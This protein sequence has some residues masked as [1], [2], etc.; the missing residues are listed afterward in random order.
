MKK[1]DEGNLY[2]DREYD[3][4][5]EPLEIQMSPDQGKNANKIFY[6]EPEDIEKY[7]NG[8]DVEATNPGERE[9]DEVIANRQNSDVVGVSEEELEDFLVSGDRSADDVDDDDRFSGMDDVFGADLEEGSCTEQEIAEGTCGH[10]HTADGEELS[11]PGGT[12]GMNANTR[13]TLIAIREE[14]NQLIK[15]I[16]KRKK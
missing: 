5:N 10:T 4:G 12:N 11:T 2:I 9:H 8:E 16:K 14:I 7:V 6:I 15:N 3:P 1:D 13:T